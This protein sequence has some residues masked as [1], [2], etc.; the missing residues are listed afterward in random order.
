[1]LSMTA[2]FRQPRPPAPASSAAPSARALPQCAAAFLSR[3]LQWVCGVCLF[4]VMCLL[5]LFEFFRA[6]LVHHAHTHEKF[7]SSSFPLLLCT[8][9]FLRNGISSHLSL[10]RSFCLPS[11]KR[12]P[13]TGPSRPP[14]R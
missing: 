9:R 12:E 10:S 2:R 11:L 6:S 1:M 4:Y 8:P 14:R 5:C 7:V 13:R 3:L